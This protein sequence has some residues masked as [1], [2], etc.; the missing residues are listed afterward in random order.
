LYDDGYLEKDEDIPNE[1]SD[2]IKWIGRKYD[3]LRNTLS[4]SKIAGFC[5][6]EELS[7]YFYNGIRLYSK[8]FGNNGLAKIVGIEPD[9]FDLKHIWIE[10]LYNRYMYLFTDEEYKNNF[11][12]IVNTLRKTKSYL[13]LNGSFK[14]FKKTK[15]PN[16]AID[17]FQDEGQPMLLDDLQQRLENNEQ[18]LELDKFFEDIREFISFNNLS[19][20]D[21]KKMHILLEV[22]F[23]RNFEESHIDISELLNLFELMKLYYSE[24]SKLY[25]KNAISLWAMLNTT[26]LPINIREK[27]VNVIQ[28]SVLRLAAANSYKTFKENNPDAI[29]WI[30]YNQQNIFKYD[31]IISTRN[32]DKLRNINHSQNCYNFNLTKKQIEYLFKEL[33]KRKYIDK[34]SKADDFAF[35]LTG[36]PSDFKLQFSP[37]NWIGDNKNSLAIFLGML[38]QFDIQM[39]SWFWHKSMK[40]F[41]YKDEEFMAKQLSSPYGKYLNHPETRNRDWSI[42]E[43]II[44]EVTKMSIS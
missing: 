13:R 38:K 35:A 44:E 18:E 29:D 25:E 3:I 7:T 36:C 6:H 11:Y 31:D 19:D 8:N 26:F 40:L 28:K 41:L 10:F 15:F 9:K 39:S 33:I 42:M 5:K 37:I 4:D 20:K 27:I 32:F 2:Q 14:E 16:E 34:R 24:Q 30:F 17:D 23:T 21:L 43:K 22:I 12:L 1:F